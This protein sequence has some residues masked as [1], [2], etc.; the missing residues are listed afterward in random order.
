MSVGQQ[1]LWLTA[2]SDNVMPFGGLTKQP[3]PVE[4]VLSNR[5]TFALFEVVVLGWH[6]NGE[7]H[8]GMSDPDM[9]RALVLIEM[10][11]RTIV[12]EIAG[13]ASKP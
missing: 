7:F 12:D 9:A 5:E 4:R 1:R 10:A 11:R 6:D 3:L 13:R 8:L 2:M